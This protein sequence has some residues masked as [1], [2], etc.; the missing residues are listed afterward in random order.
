MYTF[1]ASL[2]RAPLNPQKNAPFLLHSVMYIHFIPTLSP[3]R[4][5]IHGK[6]VNLKLCF[7]LGRNPGRLILEKQKTYK[8]YSI[9]QR[10]HDLLILIRF[11]H[12]L[13]EQLCPQFSGGSD[14]GKSRSE[15]YSRLRGRHIGLFLARLQAVGRAKPGP[16]RPG[17][18]G[19]E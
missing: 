3:H 6:V 7:N 10:D 18:A 16:I 5:S 14:A 9:L 4:V 1:N 17:Q 12:I 2:A 13:K 8:F 15:P 19:P 11:G